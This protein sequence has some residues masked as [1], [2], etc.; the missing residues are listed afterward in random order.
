MLSISKSMPVILPA[1]SGWALRSIGQ[2][3]EP[4]QCVKKTYGAIFI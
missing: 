4:D 2:Y 1:S 3:A